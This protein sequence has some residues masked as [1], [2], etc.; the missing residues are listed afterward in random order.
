MSNNIWLNQARNHH[1]DDAKQGRMLPT[2]CRDLHIQLQ[3][4]WQSTV[5]S[6]AKKLKLGSSRIIR[7]GFL[8]SSSR[9]PEESQ[10]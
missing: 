6:R 5:A 4:L 8:L 10:V 3:Q 2:K 9:W 7:V 1:E